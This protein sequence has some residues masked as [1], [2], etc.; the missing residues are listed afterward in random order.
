MRV[1]D[2]VAG[3]FAI[4]RAIG[5]GGMGSV[6]LAIDQL[7]GGSVAV[8]VVDVLYAGAAERFSAEARMLSDLSHP[9]IVRY[10]AHG[11]SEAREPFIVMEWLEGEDLA[12]R[13]SRGALGVEEAI[14]LA[15]R[16][17]EGLAFAHARGIVHRDVKPSNVFLQ[18]ADALRV[19]LLDFGVAKRP[20]G[21]QAATS[22]GAMLGT[23]G[24]MAPEQATAARDVDARADVFAL[25]CVLFECLT[26]RAAF[27]GRHA[28]AVLAKV[29]SEAAPKV[30]AVRAG[31]GDAVDRLVARLLEKD[32]RNRPAD[33]AA[34]LRLLEELERESGVEFAPSEAP[35]AS[36]TRAERRV[37]S[38]VL[39]E[40]VTR[41]VAQTLTP[42]EARRELLEL[43]D[44]G[45]RYGAEASLLANG[46][47]LLVLSGQGAA[48]DRAAQA[49]ACTLAL[50][51]VAP[52]LCIVLTTG[53]AGSTSIGPEGPAIDRAAT[54]LRSSTVGEDARLDGILIDEI[55]ARLLGSGFE[56]R[57]AAGAY[58]LVGE[59]NAL[60]GPS[61]LL[62]KPTP[63]VGR[64]KELA[65]LE[66][67]L[68]ECIADRAPRVALVTGP[69]GAGKSRLARELLQRAR[70]D[71]TARVLV[72]RGDSVAA[73]SAFWMARQLIRGAIELA[74][75]DPGVPPYEALHHRLRSR[76]DAKLAEVSAEFLCELLGTP[77]GNPSAPLRAVQNDPAQL[78][79]WMRR[80]FVEWLSVEAAEP[81][82]VVLEDLHWGDAPSVAYLEDAVRE[83]ELPL[84]VLCLARPE[85][86]DLFPRSW[87]RLNAQELRLGG[88]RRRAAE[89]LVQAVLGE[90]PAT[91]VARI[92]DQADG[93]AFYLEEL[94]RAVAEG[95]DRTLPGS[96]VAM[97]HAGLERL[98]PEARRILRA[99][100][101]IGEKFSLSAIDALAGKDANTESVLAEL[102][103][104]E[105]IAKVRALGQTGETTYAFRHALL[106]DAAYET[107]TLA[108]RATAHRLAAGFLERTKDPDPL[109]MAEHL[110]KADEPERA[111]P[112]LLRAAEAVYR[113]GTPGVARQLAERGK[114]YAKG[115]DLG[116]FKVVAGWSALL[117]GEHQ[118][119][120]EELRGANAL[121]EPGS[122]RW[123]VAV[124]TLAYASTVAG[125][126]APTM[127]LVEALE[128]L[129]SLPIDNVLCT[130][131]LA[132]AVNS[133]VLACAHTRARSLVRRIEA[134]SEKHPTLEP[135][136]RGW[137][138]VARAFSAMAGITTLGAAMQAARR[139]VALFEEAS[140][141]LSLPTALVAA[142]TMDGCI[143]RYEEASRCLEK[144]A[145]FAEGKGNF[146]TPTV[147]R[148]LGALARA[149]AGDRERALA[150]LEALVD[151]AN[152]F[153]RA[154]ASWAL[155][156][157][158]LLGGR[159]EAAR[160]RAELT[161]RMGI[162]LCATGARSTLARVELSAGRATEALA[163]AERC[164]SE[165]M[166]D[167]FGLSDDAGVV[168]AEALMALAEK[169][170]AVRALAR[171]H[172]LMMVSARTLDG[173][174]RAMYLGQV[175][176]NVRL[177][178]LAAEWG[179][180]I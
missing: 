72:A 166:R 103:R 162:P 133:L 80:S 88:L 20:E 151:D 116:A 136:C 38:V 161:L 31:V 96:V 66:A 173:E 99:A 56:I 102:E 144:G 104:S 70:K 142:A 13:L 111:V 51:Q 59:R 37:V 49:A 6:Y 19:K 171:A 121:L 45:I 149:L 63:C 180:E 107:L 100:S 53:W 115:A 44:V 138:D 90:L 176:S 132:R 87:A 46:T 85:V 106:R 10:V 54:L 122:E 62:G 8:K 175:E 177:V 134:E 25:G 76:L 110:E 64:E 128:Q 155:G 112:W 55:T 71:A 61:R 69:P 43:S 14:A 129:P 148:P 68:H 93:N 67:T 84:M 58:V 47:L 79:D 7:D 33:A 140:D 29:L 108:D 94:I 97:A 135:S 91:K 119:A 114:L 42:D 83:R 23:V 139:S 21:T 98:E 27:A 169:E 89:Q 48:K 40:A 156:R 75:A 57:P 141:T 118:A 174:D 179:V 153:S 36:L 109:A 11:V 5:R 28:V 9:G 131:A 17:C 165:P 137:L 168:R 60:E 15:K 101:V 178:R 16:M 18:G 160:D 95:R 126:P 113:A 65:L 73:G 3:R 82:L 145:A 123:F 39:A 172:G 167:P 2:L 4:R 170:A 41:D 125:D 124:A 81:L 164:L 105:V 52:E 130:S 147:M 26:G 152:P 32:P 163:A 154:I 146:I 50:R 150:E 22:T 34:V 92:V 30:S 120:K 12:E 77:A 117:S 1:G 143:G 24:Y 86:Q 159:L 78:A 35:P 127:P 157:V 158:L 74:E